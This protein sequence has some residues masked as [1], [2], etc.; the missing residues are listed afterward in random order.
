MIILRTEDYSAFLG[1]HFSQTLP[2]AFAFTQQGCSQS[3]PAAFALSQQDS[4]YVAEE[5]S[6][7]KTPARMILVMFI[8]APFYSGFERAAIGNFDILS[9]QICPI[10]G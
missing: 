9:W 10:A 6:T 2:A 4:A 3:L 5:A 8:G 7:A 1:L